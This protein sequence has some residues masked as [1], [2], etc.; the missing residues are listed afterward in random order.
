MGRQIILW[1]YLLI[2]PFASAQRSPWCMQADTFT[3]IYDS[4]KITVQ[5]SPNKLV[6]INRIESRKCVLITE[7][8]VENNTVIQTRTAL[9]YLNKSSIVIDSNS[10][11][12]R[13]SKIK[14]FKWPNEKVEMKLKAKKEVLNTELSVNGSQN[15]FE[16]Q[17][18]FDSNCLSLVS[19]QDR[20]KRYLDSMSLN[21]KRVRFITTIDQKQKLEKH[22]CWINGYLFSFDDEQ[23]EKIKGKK[24]KIS[25]RITIGKGSYSPY[26][27]R[28]YSP[29]G[30]QLLA[31]G[32]GRD[33][34]MISEPRIKILKK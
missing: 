1:W 10:F 12:A 24:V 15:V 16:L 5:P 8:F 22:N 18:Y 13:K 34:M 3:I 29:D 2:A 23:F 25:G 31:Q 6:V 7:Y 20:S 11:E 4:I 26:S 9:K 14:S 27:K 33:V 17:F 32:L 19:A 21:N 28:L 30:R